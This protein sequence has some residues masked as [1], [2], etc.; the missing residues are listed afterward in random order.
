M[1][2]QH[3][4]RV[5]NV[6]KSFSGFIAIKGASLNVRRGGIHALIGPNGAGKSTLFNLVTKFTQPDS[7]SIFFNDEEVTHLSPADIAMKGLVR[8]FQISS[9]FPHLT[10]LENVRFA[11][12]RKTGT[13]FTFWRSDR[14]LAGMHDKAMSLLHDV[15]LGAF[16]HR[17]ASE[18]SYGRRRALEI[19]TTL[20]LDPELLLLDE[21]MAG[22]GHEDIVR[23][24][25]L[26]QQIATRK[27]VLMV[28]HNLSV[29]A[30]ISSVI[31]V[32]QRGEIIAEGPYASV[33][34]DPRV[35][36]AYLGRDDD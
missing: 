18:F 16:P 1:A 27:T 31:S 7:G 22:M 29:V 3:V 13:S 30:E 21:P 9:V 11:L 19:A 6:S 14:V 33:S 20:A 34:R 17:H 25:S 36:E 23:T 15:G 10:A 2:S 8:S 28:E 26:I 24:S 35:I 4:L 5:E 12:Q 32:L